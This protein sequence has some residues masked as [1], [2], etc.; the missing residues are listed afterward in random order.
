MRQASYELLLFINSIL[1]GWAAKRTS[2]GAVRQPCS[3]HREEHQLRVSKGALLRLPVLN[4]TLSPCLRCICRAFSVLEQLPYLPVKKGGTKVTG[5]P[6]TTNVRPHTL[7]FPAVLLIKKPEESSIK[8][9]LRKAN[10]WY[11]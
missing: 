9:P 7:L 2:P 6:S 10:A 3:G 8:L 5:L 4:P 11:A 1:S